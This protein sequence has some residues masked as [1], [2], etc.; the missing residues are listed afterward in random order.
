MFRLA[1]APGRPDPTTRW[2][3]K[4]DGLSVENLDVRALRTGVRLPPPPPFQS[5]PPGGR[6]GRSLEGR[7]YLLIRT[8]QLP[9]PSG[10]M[11]TSTDR[12]AFITATL[13]VACRDSEA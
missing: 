7:L 3:N 9:C 8:R 6:D 4:K 5:E 12:N 13:V 1:T 11:P 2:L 10:S